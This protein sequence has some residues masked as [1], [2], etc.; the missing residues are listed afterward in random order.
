MFTARQFAFALGL[1]AICL[2]NAFADEAAIRKNLAARLP[3]LPP[4][5]EVSKTPLPGIWEVRMGSEILYTD[6]TAGFVIEG[7]IIDLQNK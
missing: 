4:V 1:S 2:A 7:N 6:D 3:Q 5:D